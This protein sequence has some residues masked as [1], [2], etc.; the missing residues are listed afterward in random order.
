[1]SDERLTL[2]HEENITVAGELH[3]NNLNV[4]RSLGIGMFHLAVFTRRRELEELERHGK[5]NIV[6]LLQVTD[7]TLMLGCVF[8][9]F[10]ISLVSYMRSIQLMKLLEENNWEL[11]HLQERAIQRQLREAYSSYIENVAP[12][13]LQW[14]NKIAAHRAATDP[15][16]DN[17]SLL[18]YS[19]LPTVSYSSPYY[20][21]GG[22]T[23]SMGDGSTSDLEPW[24]LTEKY[25]ELTPRFWP[26]Q[27]LPELGW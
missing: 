16:S 22:Y 19:T 24:S 26:S 12:D 9:W 3:H 6:E 14:R 15:R 11:E 10:S 25:E 23:I 5:D 1:M 27:E 21:V 2:D 13:V 7:E 4:L 20:V 8:D 18:T 17:L